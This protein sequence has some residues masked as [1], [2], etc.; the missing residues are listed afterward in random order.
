M[1]LPDN[2]WQRPHHQ[3]FHW[4]QSQYV[5]DISGILDWLRNENISDVGSPMAKVIF[6]GDHFMVSLLARSVWTPGTS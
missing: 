2:N 6:K 1:H 4:C 3:V 5:I